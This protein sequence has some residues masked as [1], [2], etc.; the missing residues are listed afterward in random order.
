GLAL[1]RSDDVVPY[2]LVKI[3]SRLADD[4][5]Q[6]LEIAARLAQHGGPGEVVGHVI[7][8][9]FLPTIWRSRTPPLP[10]NARLALI[11]SWFR[12]HA[13]KTQQAPQG[14]PT[15]NATLGSRRPA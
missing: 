3:L 8:C 4:L 5:V 6:V 9:V 12:S 1:G 15:G 10:R 14:H 7:H 2:V 13:G 11:T